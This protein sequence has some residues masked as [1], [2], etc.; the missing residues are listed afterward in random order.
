MVQQHTRRKHRIENKRQSQT[1]KEERQPPLSWGSP[2][3][4]WYLVRA[5]LTQ[6]G[7]CFLALPGGPSDPSAAYCCPHGA[8]WWRAAG[9]GRAHPWHLPRIGLML[10]P[11]QLA[12]SWVE[13]LE[14]RSRSSPGERGG[15][16]AERLCG[17]ALPGKVSRAAYL[18]HL[19][20]WINLCGL[21]EQTGECLDCA[22]RSPGSVGQK[23][24]HL[25]VVAKG[26]Q[27]QP[28]STGGTPLPDPTEAWVPGSL[29]GAKVEVSP[30]PSTRPY[31]HGVMTA[32]RTC[33]TWDNCS[34]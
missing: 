3:G 21:K 26:A 11:S 4:R 25:P 28:L 33:L 19:E 9:L 17:C 23:K 24:P 31:S 13:A 27:R 34:A 7:P 16:K 32:P 1:Q 15:R 2:S 8:A 29:G 30:P 14:Y 12:F 6:A 22:S 18:L 20:C 10:S 5:H